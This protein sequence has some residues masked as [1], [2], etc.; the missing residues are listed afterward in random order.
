MCNGRLSVAAAT[1]IAPTAIPNLM[2]YAVEMILSTP[3]DN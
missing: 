2:K 1:A 3:E